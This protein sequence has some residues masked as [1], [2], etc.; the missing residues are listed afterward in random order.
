MPLY[1]QILVGRF[2]ELQQ[3]KQEIQESTN[4]DFRKN[5]LFWRNNWNIAT[6]PPPGYQSPDMKSWQQAGKLALAAEVSNEVSR[7]MHV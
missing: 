3:N 4:Q 6:Q 7:A 2:L 5:R 1:S